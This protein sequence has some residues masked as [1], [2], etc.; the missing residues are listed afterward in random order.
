MCA[1]SH[2][3]SSLLKTRWGSHGADTLAVGN[4]LQGLTERARN[5]AQYPIRWLLKTETNGTERLL[6]VEARQGSQ[7][8]GRGRTWVKLTHKGTTAV[9]QLG[10]PCL[11]RLPRQCELRSRGWQRPI[12]DLRAFTLRRHLVR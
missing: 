1:P 6:W 9:A 7:V 5:G 10:Y 2:T 8:V 3:P 12:G 4:D 11:F